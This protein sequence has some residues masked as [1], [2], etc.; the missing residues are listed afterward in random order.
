ML[1]L[2][3]TQLICFAVG[4][5]A[6][7]LAGWQAKATKLQPQK[8][9]FLYLLTVMSAD[10]VGILIQH[11]ITDV[12]P[13]GSGGWFI[14][15]ARAVDIMLYLAWSFG[16]ALLSVWVFGRERERDLLGGGIVVAWV[17]LCKV[18]MRLYPEHEASAAVITSHKELVDHLFTT[19]HIISVGIGIV[20][21]A[22]YYLAKNW[23]LLPH[24]TTTLLLAGAIS[25]CAG[26]YARAKPSADYDLSSVAG[27]MVYS[28][29]VIAHIYSAIRRAAL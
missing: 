9:V 15:T 18:A 1:G 7:I 29:V 10:F 14:R 22:R 2:T 20:F 26:E 23:P 5:L 27:I 4:L 8:A 24:L 3:T 12:V 6:T 19:A 28:F 17:V 21:T 13:Y 16:F 11:Y 25:D